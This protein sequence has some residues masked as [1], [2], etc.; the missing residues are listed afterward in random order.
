MN[1]TDHDAV[2]LDLDGVITPTAEV[3]MRAWADMF[4]AFLGSYDGAAADRAAVGA[5]GRRRR[6]R[7]RSPLLGTKI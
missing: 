1:W 5:A 3:H 2:L 4:N 7:G 6:C